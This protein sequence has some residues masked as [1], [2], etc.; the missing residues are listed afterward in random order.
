MQAIRYVHPES[1]PEM[2]RLHSFLTGSGVH[3]PYYIRVQSIVETVVCK[4]DGIQVNFYI[5]T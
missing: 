2:C 1:P 3:I 4:P 5:S